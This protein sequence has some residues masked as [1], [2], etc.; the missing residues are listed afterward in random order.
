VSASPPRFGTRVGIGVVGADLPIDEV[1][2]LAVRAERAGLDSVWAGEYFRSAF[3]TPTAIA[4]RTS[5]IGIGTAIA[6]AFVR[7]PLI[8][9]LSAIDLDE[10]SGGRFVLGLGSQVKTAIERWHGL[11]YSRP[12]SRMAET[13]R[14]IRA[15][16][17]THLEEPQRFKG[18]F[19]DLD[20]TG[21]RRLSPP[22][23]PLRIFVAGVKPAMVK[24]A[25]RVGDGVI[26][27]LFWSDRYLRETVQQITSAAAPG[28]ETCANVLCA[29]GE[30]REVAR[31]DAKRT[32]AY[33]AQTRTYADLLSA[34][35]FAQE[36][37]RARAAAASRDARAMEKAISD[38]MV[39]AY[40]VA[41]TPDEVL[42]QLRERARL[43][44][45]AI[46]LPAYY[47]TP[48]DRV[49]EQ[50]DAILETFTDDP[51]SSGAAA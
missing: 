16:A 26:G 10:L 41:G 21:Y 5:R 19:Y 17:Q 50:Y 30:D 49:R 44:D 46:A 3:V 37:E 40:A 2:D 47:L 22:L 6:L 11:E 38:R 8:A 23:R 1:I 12:A 42:G 33:Y 32:L 45:L 34:D 14:A 29:V 15:A 39:D 43:L 28:F 48:P 20:W 24:V 4:E 35:G 18:E 13:V 31:R 25:A 36:A 7:T 9:A 51:I 27:H